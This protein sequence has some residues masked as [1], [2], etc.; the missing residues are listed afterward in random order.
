[1]VVND[2]TA[3]RVELLA[4]PSC[5]SAVVP[6][7]AGL[8]CTGY[9]RTF[10]LDGRVPIMV[11][12]D[13][14]GEAQSYL[15]RVRYSVLGS[16]RLYDFHQRY[17]GAR[18]IADQVAT[19]FRAM[20]GRTLVDVGAGTGM[21]ARMLPPGT[22]YVWLDNDRLKLRG[23]LSKSLD[24]LA[25]LG[26]A[27]QLPFSDRAAD[28]TSMVEVSHH[29]PDDA[30]RACFAEAARVTRDRFL[31]V[32]ALRSDRIRSNLMW[33]VDLGRFPR[34]EQ[35][36]LALLRESF[37]LEQIVRFHVNHDHVLCVCTPRPGVG[38]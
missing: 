20:D 11:R 27:T 5:R 12:D 33:R 28:W 6:T 10:A 15:A 34:R 35:A 38:G 30:L 19:A 36:L 23:F 1:M 9:G 25:V 37:E 7:F 13:S 24:C 17:G 16:P 29:L 18:R 26:D 4:C 14:V 31:F 2:D 3:G 21:V 8:S 22:R 32:D